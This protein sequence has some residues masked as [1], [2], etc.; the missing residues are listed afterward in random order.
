MGVPLCNANL[1]QIAEAGLAQIPQY[2]RSQLKSGVVHLGPSHFGRGHVLRYLDDIAKTDPK[3]GVTM[4]GLMH[5]GVRDA[6]ADQDYLYTLKEQDGKTNPTRVIGCIK[7]MIVAREEPQKVLDVLSS[8]ETKLVTMTVTEKGYGHDPKT[9]TLD[10]DRDD[11]KK[12]LNS[13]DEPNTAIG[14]LVAALERRMNSGAPPLTIISCDNIEANGIVLRNVVL[15]YAAE[16][17]AHLRKYIE[18]NVAF[19]STMVDRI[20]PTTTDQQKDFSMAAGHISDKWPVQTEEFMQW[21]IEDNFAGEMPDLAAVGAT[22]T[23]DV[24]PFKAMKVRMLNG[25]HMAVGTLGKLA[26]YDRVHEAM[27]NETIRQ[28]VSA[29]MSEV[30]DTLTPISNV[31]FIFYIELLI[32]RLE[33]PA[34]N[35][36]NSRVVRNATLSKIKPRALDAAESAIAKE[37][38]YNHVAF[39]TAAWIHY[40]KGTDDNKAEFDINDVHAVESGLQQVARNSN[41]NPNPVI[42]MSGAFSSGLQ[43]HRGFMDTVTMHLHNIQ[44]HG[45]VGA[46]ERVN[47]QTRAPQVQMA[48]SMTYT[49]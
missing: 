18:N 29:F 32:R 36:E 27:G 42:A 49:R 7:D 22:I 2:D 23:P 38:S 30:S 3:W 31:D 4:V 40:L 26:G 33:N 28:F 13:L 16:Q 12:C 35:D 9:G 48:A 39:V 10:F 1:Q 47:Q 15:A 6:L 19:P 5:S 43:S 34:L 44:Q 25:G 41:G 14:Y 11:I 8:H 17:S 46:I 21:V 24:N 20:V 37:T 45:V